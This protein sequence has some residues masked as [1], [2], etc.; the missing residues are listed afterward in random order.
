MKLKDYQI[1]FTEIKS[2][3]HGHPNM[4]DIA[5]IS[6]FNDYVTSEISFTYVV[7]KSPRKPTV[8]MAR[9]LIEYASSCIALYKRL[10][11]GIIWIDQIPKSPSGKVIK[12][13]LKDRVITIDKVKAI[14]A[15]NFA[16]TQAARS[17]L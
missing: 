12:C 2:I 8:K 16:D 1:V 10:A 4:G 5:I 14:E 6:I 13:V 9:D 7:L 11:G 15:V 3:L 17:K